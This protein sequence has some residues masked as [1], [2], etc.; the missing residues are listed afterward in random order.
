[1]IKGETMYSIECIAYRTPV[2]CLLF[3]GFNL[4]Q[5]SIAPC[6]YPP[7]PPPLFP[8]EMASLVSGLTIFI[9]EEGPLTYNP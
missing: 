3:N 2:Y 8:L 6:V 5:S 9:L 1:M 7:I 4:I